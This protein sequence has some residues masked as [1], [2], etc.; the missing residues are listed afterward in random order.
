MPKTDIEIAQEASMLPIAEVAAKIGLGEDQL[1][2]YGR[3]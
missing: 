2:T 3:Y 1:E